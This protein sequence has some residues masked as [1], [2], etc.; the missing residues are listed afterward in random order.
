MGSPYYFNRVKIWSKLNRNIKRNINWMNLR[1]ENEGVNIILKQ[2]N[3]LIKKDKFSSLE[4]ALYYI[5]QEEES[6]KKKHKM[7][8]SK[9][10]FFN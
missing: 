9:L 6:K 1:E 4:Y 8:V 5:K 10:M 3:K 7:D 2:A